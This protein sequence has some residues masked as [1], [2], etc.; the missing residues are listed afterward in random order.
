[1]ENR[2]DL[3]GRVIIVTGS[4]G[5][6][7]SGYCKYLGSV[8]ARVI[9]WDLPSVDI[10]YEFRVQN[11][12]KQV[13]DGYGRID[14]L[15]NN[16]AMNPALGGSKTDAQFAPYEDYDIELFRRE[17]GVNVVGAM[18]CIKHVA[19]IMMQ[20]KSGSIVNV[21]SDISTIAHDH[22]VYDAG[23]SKF[24]SPGYVT[25]KSAILGLSRQWAARLGMHNVRVNAVSIGA[26]ERDGMPADFV[27][28]FGA[29]AMLNRMARS[30]EH[31]A[32]IQYLLSDASSFVTGSNLV[33]DGG[34][35]AW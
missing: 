15:V 29:T 30:T 1:M 34:K 13:V 9:G 16:A 8:G 3:T 5:F 14:G 27:C 35:A 12:V 7:G 18:I 21:A 22:R 25:S 31:C 26:V 19:P 28:R 33:A 10:T 2:F 4:E 11:A 6:L 20:Q 17:I 23:E 32:T 24:K